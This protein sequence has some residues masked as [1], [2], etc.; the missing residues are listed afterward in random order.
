MA[1]G[2]WRRRKEKGKPAEL[3]V[4]YRDS[5]GLR[6]REK[7]GPESPENL[8][9]AKELLARKQLESFEPPRQHRPLKRLTFRDLGENYWR[10]LGAQKSRTWRCMLELLYE[11]LGASLADELTTKDLQEFYNRKIQTRSAST[12]NRY[13][14]LIN[15]VYN[16]GIEWGDIKGSNPASGVRRK[17]E[18]PS[19]LR[20]LS[21]QELETF[22]TVCQQPRF[23]RL[24][25][26]VVCALFTG[27][28]R[29]E[30]MAL[31]WQNI[32]LEHGTIYILHSKSGKPREIPIAAKLHE[33]LVSVGPKTA[34]PVFEIPDITCRRLFDLA[35][36]QSKL[37]PFRFH[38]LR[39]TFASHFA[40]KTNDMLALQ[41]I[42]GHASP[43]MT[44]RYAHL[45][46]GHLDAAIKQFDASMPELDIDSRPN[47]LEIRASVTINTI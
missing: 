35:K 15:T 24:Y 23:A 16:R 7:V 41:R 36:L 5:K 2:I 10:L 43:Q 25:P 9:L 39:H 40:M 6:H 31:D 27:M 38:D 33:V 22:L 45:S 34:G 8:R 19:R 3:Y 11:D 47:P 1:R 29:G 26:V 42:L 4:V 18:S 28:R 17:P 44:Q 12:A 46:R 14:T 30:I 21:L 32:N 20:Y 37:P 13:L